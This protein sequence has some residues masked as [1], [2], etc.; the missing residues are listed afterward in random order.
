[1]VGVGA[2]EAPRVDHSGDEVEPLL[3]E[4]LQV[5]AAD[6]RGALDVGQPEPALLPGRPQAA[7]DLEHVATLP[8]RSNQV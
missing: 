8:E 5:A 4:R 1:M 6:S 7:A 3:L 2:E